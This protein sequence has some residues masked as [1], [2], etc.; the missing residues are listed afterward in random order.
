MFYP[1]LNRKVLRILLIFDLGSSGCLMFEFKCGDGKCV[2][3]IYQ[4]D[5]DID[6]ANGDDERNCEDHN[7]IGNGTFQHDGGTPSQNEAN[8]GWFFFNKQFMHGCVFWHFFGCHVSRRKVVGTVFIY[9]F[10]YL[11]MLYLLTI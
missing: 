11:Q 6:C 9:N 3:Y 1:K 2:P 10:K 7:L 5:G 8:A 4:C